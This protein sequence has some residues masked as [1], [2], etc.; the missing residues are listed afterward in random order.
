MH[1]AK[2][3]FIVGVGRSG[4]SLLQSIIGTH[5]SV[6][7]ISETSFLRRYAFNKNVAWDGIHN[8]EMLLRVPSLISEIKDCK[9]DRGGLIEAYKKGLLYP[10]KNRYVLDKDPRLIEYIDLLNLSNKDCKIIIIRRDPRDV[11]SSKKLAKWSKGRSIL[12]YLLAS[13]IQ[14]SDGRCHR[15]DK[16]IHS[17]DYE[18]LLKEP[19]IQLQELC[20]FLELEFESNMLNFQ[21]TSRKLIKKDELS[22]KKETMQ[23]ILASNFGK[24]KQVLTDV[25]ACTSVMVAKSADPNIPIFDAS[26]YSFL[27]RSKS[28]L[29]KNIVRLMVFVYLF[30]REKKQNFVKREI[31][32]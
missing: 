27:T 16:N 28:V 19:I 18:M 13:Y 17:L 21:D 3:L 22:W 24:W 8:D 10:S 6:D 2:S 1:V 9:N 7:V 31:V 25:E 11:L 14:L 26:K 5:S 12:S 30:L 4:T 23:P 15:D 20:D 32:E 29:L